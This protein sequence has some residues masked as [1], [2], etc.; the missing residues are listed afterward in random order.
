MRNRSR[1]AITL[2]VALAVAASVAVAI[3]SAGTPS[4]A[5]VPLE[6]NN[7]CDNFTGKK[8]KV[9]SLTVT[10][11]KNG[12]IRMKIVDRGIP[13]ATVTIYP[14]SDSP[15]SCDYYYDSEGYFGHQPKLKLDSSGEGSVT[16][17]FTPDP[18]DTDWGAE[19]Y[20]NATGIYDVSPAVHV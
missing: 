19:A 7:T 13:N 12:D 11:L 1:Q 2:A 6:H 5:K 3:S 4:T 14:W 18:G 9:G 20:D 17:T 16:F 10:R 15:D 8:S